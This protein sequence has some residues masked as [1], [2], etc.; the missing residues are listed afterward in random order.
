MND[1][2]ADNCLSAR[3]DAGRILFIDE[4]AA[5]NILSG[6]IGFKI[7]FSRIAPAGKFYKF[8]FGKNSIARCGN[9]AVALDNTQ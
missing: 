5:I 7:E 8:T 2:I 6:I 9:S 4:N 3:K 1:P